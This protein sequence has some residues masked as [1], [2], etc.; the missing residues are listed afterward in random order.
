MTD[1]KLS[2]TYL[3]TALTDIEGAKA[4]ARRIFELYD[5]DRSGVIENYEIGSM[6]VDAYRSINKIFTPSKYDVDTYVKVLD[7]NN[8]GKVTL[9]DV[10]QLVIKYLVGEYDAKSFS[11]ENIKDRLYNPVVQQQLEHARRIFQRYDEDK[12]GFIDEHEVAPI[13]RDTYKAMG[14][15]FQPTKSDVESYMKMMDTNRDGKISLDEYEQLVLKSLAAR[16]IHI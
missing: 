14:I 8:D 11:K 1:Y 12:S 10:E 15:D 4:L 2:G 6:M 13:L 3:G 16:G 9:Q 5:K 7:R